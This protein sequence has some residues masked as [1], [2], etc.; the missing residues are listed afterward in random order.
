MNYLTT[1][2]L[3]PAPE[4]EFKSPFINE[5]LADKD[6]CSKVVVPN[7]HILPLFGEDS[8]SICLI[9]SLTSTLVLSTLMA[10]VSVSYS[11]WLTTIGTSE[12][13]NKELLLSVRPSLKVLT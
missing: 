9:L 8:Y 7:H 13:L 10:V 12:Y 1:N 3:F 5:I 6:C 2:F 4:F 11:L